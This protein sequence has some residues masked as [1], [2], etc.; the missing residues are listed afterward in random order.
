MR[1]FCEFTFYIVITEMC[2]DALLGRLLVGV[3]VRLEADGKAV[4]IYIF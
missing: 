4:Y 3:P 2:D 1:E